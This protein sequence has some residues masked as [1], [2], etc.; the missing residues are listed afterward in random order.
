MF[1]ALIA[2]ICGHYVGETN[3]VEHPNFAKASYKEANWHRLA[4][5]RKKYDPDQ[6]FFGFSDGLTDS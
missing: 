1:A 3:S 4:Q 2:H 5:L 6:V